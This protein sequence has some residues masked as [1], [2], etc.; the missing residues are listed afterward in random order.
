MED[1]PQGCVSVERARGD[2][3]VVFHQEGTEINLA[4]NATREV[5]P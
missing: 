4:P 2:H 1:V 3:G 5:A